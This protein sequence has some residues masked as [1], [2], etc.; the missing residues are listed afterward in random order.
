MKNKN[1]DKEVSFSQSFVV[2]MTQNN[3]SQRSGGNK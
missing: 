1:P 3:S 2:P